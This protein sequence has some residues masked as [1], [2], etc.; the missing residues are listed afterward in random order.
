MDTSTNR[1]LMELEQQMRTVNRDTLNPAFPELC[2]NDFH[3]VAQMVANARE[4]YLSELFA[5]GEATQGKIPSNEMIS[6]LRQKRECFD[7]LV[8]AAQALEAATQR[9]YLDVSSS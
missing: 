3:A 9:G 2:V 6:M 8:A 4:S 1:L 7:E 5:M